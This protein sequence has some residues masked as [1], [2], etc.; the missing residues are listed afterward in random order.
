M[1]KAW[2]NSHLFDLVL[3]AVAAATGYSSHK[4]DFVSESYGGAKPKSSS[5]EVSK[6]KDSRESLWD[7]VR[8][9]NIQI[10]ATKRVKSV[11][12]DED[13]VDGSNDV[14]LKEYAN[15]RDMLNDFRSTGVGIRRRLQA[16]NSWDGQILVHGYD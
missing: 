3:F 10:V 7:A 14:L 1:N 2:S 15:R 5:E 16:W 13:D 8:Q 12:E 11:F 4:L 9:E 6:K